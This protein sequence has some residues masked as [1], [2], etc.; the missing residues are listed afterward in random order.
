ML[1]LLTTDA[2]ADWFA[3]LDDRAAEDVATALDV[4]ERLEPAQAP[5]A[6]RKSL[7]WYEHPTSDE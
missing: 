6:S 4:V 7:L 2:F 1:Q 3:A 5:P